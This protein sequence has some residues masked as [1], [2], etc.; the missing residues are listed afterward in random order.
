MKRRAKAIT[1]PQATTAAS[2]KAREAVASLYAAFEPRRR[3]CEARY[4]L[5]QGTDTT[6]KGA[7]HHRITKHRG[8]AAAD[9][10]YDD[11][12][13]IQRARRYLYEGNTT[14][15]R[16][17]ELRARLEPIEGVAAVDGLIEAMREEW[18]C[19]RDWW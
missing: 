7:L 9:Q 15:D 11:M 6:M 10:L 2:I 5:A 18:A 8:Q 3:R 12:R 16:V 4:W 1:A 13:L 17:R 19:R 14:A